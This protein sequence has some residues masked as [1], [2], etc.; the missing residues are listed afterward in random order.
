MQHDEIWREEIARQMNSQTL[1][2][3]RTAIAPAVTGIPTTIEP[4][5]KKMPLGDELRKLI[6]THRRDSFGAFMN[7]VVA[8][9]NQTRNG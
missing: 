1:E 8:S 3:L 6:A 4:P 9:L 5:Q 7:S 2:T